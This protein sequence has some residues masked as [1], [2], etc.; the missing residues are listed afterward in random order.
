MKE[1]SLHGG[2]GVSPS[3]DAGGVVVVVE[4]EPIEVCVV[5]GTS[6]SITGGLT[7]PTFAATGCKRTR[8]AWG[9]VGSS[10]LASQVSVQSLPSKNE[11]TIDSIPP[12]IGSSGGVVRT[13]ASR[14]A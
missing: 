7:S 3:G 10:W 1:K 13:G 9:K 11:T 4:E 14:L 5:H 8:M 2:G 12:S 6:T